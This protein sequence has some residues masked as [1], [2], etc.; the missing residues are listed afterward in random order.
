MAPYIWPRSVNF[1]LPYIQVTYL[2]AETII[3]FT[4]NALLEGNA[5]PKIMDLY[6][7]FHPLKL[8]YI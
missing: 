4:D 7:F 3:D 6:T 1:F 2:N 8:T 5:D